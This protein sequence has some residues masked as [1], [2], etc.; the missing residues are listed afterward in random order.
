MRLCFRAVAGLM[1]I[2]WALPVVVGQPPGPSAPTQPAPAGPAKPQP[3][4]P[5]LTVKVFKLEHGNPEVVVESLNSLLE[6]PDAEVVA[7]MTPGAPSGTPPG[8]LSG[9]GAL[10]PG[11]RPGGFGGTSG[12]ASGQAGF[13]PMVPSGAIGCFIG[14]GGANS[15]PVWRATAQVRTRA[16]I[17]RG[18]E[19]HLK[20]AA[21]LVAILDRPANAPLPEL[22]VIKA[23]ALKHATAQELAEVIEAL[24]FEDVKLA[25]LDGHL[26]ALIAPDDVVKSVA[27]L[28]R[29]LDVA[30]NGEPRPKTKTE[31][32]KGPKPNDSKS[33]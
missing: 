28:V 29:E 26:L 3:T 6:E 24:S 30:G 15:T 27:E 22:R 20:V 10:P 1:A 23:F 33:Y 21:D 5:K 9:M 16:V 2:A 31:L 12:P 7:P 14:T 8:G 4:K 11:G 19:Q 13:G 25:T 17:V 18:S 32:K